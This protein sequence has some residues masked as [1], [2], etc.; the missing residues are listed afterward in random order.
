MSLG[1]L[2]KKFREL[3]RITQKALG[4]RTHL[5]GVRIRPVILND[6]EPEYTNTD[7]YFGSEAILRIRNMLDQW[8]EMKEKYENNEIT[9]EAL[10]D[11][12]ANYPDSLKKDYVPFEESNVK[13][14]RKGITAK[15]PP[16]IIK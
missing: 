16:D 9:K 10:Q 5:D 3:R 14:Y 13:F 7:I 15:V 8:Q 4:G 6:E 2:I 11:W 1:K 12:K